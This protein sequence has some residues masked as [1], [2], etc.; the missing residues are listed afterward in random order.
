MTEELAALLAAIRR[1]EAPKGYGQ[2]YGGAR[3]VSLSTDVSRLTLNEVLAFQSQMLASG[4]KSSACGGYQFLKGTLKNTIRTMGL[5]GNEVWTPTLQDQMAIQLMKGRGL[6]R[7]MAGTISAET[8]A[9]NLAMEW[10]S[11][12]VVTYING[13]KPGQSYYAGDG[14]NGSNHSVSEI[15]ALVKDLKKNTPQVERPDV[16][17]VSG[18]SKPR[19]LLAAL[20]ELLMLIFKGR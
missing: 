5:T 10:A 7:Y 3:G 2:I 11:L 18:N 8:F 15:M 6:D 14:L 4:S 9:N 19:G 17:V 13:K 1:G 12:P 20:I 16:E